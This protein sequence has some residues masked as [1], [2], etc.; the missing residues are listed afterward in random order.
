MKNKSIKDERTQREKTKII[1]LPTYNFLFVLFSG[2]VFV[3]YCCS[4]EREALFHGKAFWSHKYDACQMAFIQNDVCLRGGQTNLTMS[5]LVGI[6]CY[7]NTLC[8]VTSV[9]NFERA[10]ETGCRLFYPEFYL[11]TLFCWYDFGCIGHIFRE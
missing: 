5:N 9:E 7:A 8:I 11:E 10:E 1:F 6:D 2:W 3:H 4:L